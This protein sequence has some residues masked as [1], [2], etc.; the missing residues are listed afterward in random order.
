M[1]AYCSALTYLVFHDKARMI[2]FAADVFRRRSIIYLFSIKYFKQLK[3][4]KKVASPRLEEGVV[5]LTA[6]SAN[7][8]L[9]TS[10]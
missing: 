10:N 2:V 1:K 5:D 6:Q 7:Q 3:L 4:E 8:V 9:P